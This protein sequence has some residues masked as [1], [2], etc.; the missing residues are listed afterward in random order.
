M[1]NTLNLLRS[2]AVGFIDLLDALC[3]NYFTRVQVN[4]WFWFCANADTNL[5]CWRS[6]ITSCSSWP[7]ISCMLGCAHVNFMTS[8]FPERRQVPDKT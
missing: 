7:T 2:G 1:A 8:A 5:S 6:E 4:F 3:R